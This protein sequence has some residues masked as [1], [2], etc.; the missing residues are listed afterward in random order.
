MYKNYVH[1]MKLIE[2]TF[3]TTKIFW[4]EN[5]G[6]LEA[7]E[8]TLPIKIIIWKRTKHVPLKIVLRFCTNI[9][10]LIL[11]QIK[12]IV[13]QSLYTV[14]YMSWKCKYTGDT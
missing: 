7:L 10:P 12:M 4:H 14:Q 3:C 8:I 1:M 2:W 13:M 9:S 11:H 5:I 6:E